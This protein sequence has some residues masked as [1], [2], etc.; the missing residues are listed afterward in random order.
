MASN[1]ET[2]K[3]PIYKKWWFWVIVVLVIFIIIGATGNNEET[4]KTTLTSSND[5]TSSANE[6]IN[7][8]KKSQYSVGEIYEDSNIAIKFVSADENYTGYS[9]YADVKD[10]CKIIKAE[11][12]A[13][14]TG[15]ADAYFS[16]YN[17]DCYAD[18]YDCEAFWSFDDSG[19][20]STLSSR[21]KAKGTVCFQVPVNATSI[22]IEYKLNSFTGDKVEF[23]VK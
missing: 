19:F 2:E 8:A 18:G 15:T 21:K 17:F 16:A 7:E 23:L 20:S 11:F 5:T 14:N 3:K 6:T 9:Q 10:G 12:E 4:S 22:S 1:E 13:E